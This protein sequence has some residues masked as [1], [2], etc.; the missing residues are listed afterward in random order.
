[1]NKSGSFIETEGT[2]EPPNGRLFYTVAFFLAIFLSLSL[3]NALV[4]FV[5]ALHT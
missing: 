2:T 5:I 3:L 1:M 4:S